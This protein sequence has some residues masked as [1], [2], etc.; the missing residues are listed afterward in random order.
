MATQIKKKKEQKR[1]R[2]APA[3]YLIIKKD[4]NEME[5]DGERDEKYRH[6]P[7]I[8]GI[9]VYFS[10]FI[11]FVWGFGQKNIE[12]SPNVHHLNSLL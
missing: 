8:M 10:Q 2:I 7:K 5:R 12:K 3:H 4:G 6:T 11:F 9:V 1:K